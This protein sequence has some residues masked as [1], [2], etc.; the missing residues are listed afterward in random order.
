LASLVGDF[1]TYRGSFCEP[2]DEEPEKMDINSLASVIFN[3]QTIYFC[4]AIYVVTYLIRRVFEGTFKILVQT[5]E[6]KKGSIV[7]RIWGEILVPVL[8]IL[9]GGGLSF[10]A[11]T[12]VWPDFTMKTKLARVIYGC[13]CGLFSA[14]IYNRIRGWLK[15]KTDI[16]VGDATEPAGL[17]DPVLG[18][19]PPEAAKEEPPK[20]DPP[21]PA[22]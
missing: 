1:S 22:A 12:F 2:L 8:P 19:V 4:L 9:V 7:G 13:I 17:T 10:A 15:S 3:V 6:V 18:S 11:K 5:G 21:K 20:V 14:F 16:T